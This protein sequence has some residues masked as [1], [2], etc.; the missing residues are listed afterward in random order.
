MAREGKKDGYWES[1]AASRFQHH[2][3]QRLDET[4]RFISHK[5]RERAHLPSLL[6][7]LII[8]GQV[9]K[10]MMSVKRSADVSQVISHIQHAGTH[11]AIGDLRC[12]HTRK[13]YKYALKIMQ[14]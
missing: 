5:G 6:E 8:G 1:R 9:Q 7:V 13:K 14:T 10:D 4:T 2:L 3:G 12:I 11:T